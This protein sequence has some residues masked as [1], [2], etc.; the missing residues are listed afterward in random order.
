MEKKNKWILVC[1]MV[2]FLATIVFAQ[3]FVTDCRKKCSDERGNETKICNDGYKACRVECGEEKKTCLDNVKQNHTA[4]NNNC[5]ERGCIRECS[6]KMIEE[7][8]ECGKT[9]CLKEC[10]DTRN[11]CRDEAKN[12]SHECREACE[13]NPY[14]VGEDECEFYHEIC[15]GPYFDVICSKDKFCICDG[16]KNYSC[17]QNYTCS[18]EIEEFLPRK[19]HTVQGYRDLLGNDLGDIGVCKKE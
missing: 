7:K 16:D 6:K 12:K 2:V 19:K 3:S 13:I 10:R 5:S 8:K 15:N 1:F 4:C 9:E 18:H 11:V 14:E 17:P